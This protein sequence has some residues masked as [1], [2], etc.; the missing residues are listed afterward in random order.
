MN[1]AAQRLGRMAKGVKKT[2]S[3]EEI[4]RRTAQLERVRKRRW[5]SEIER[6]ED[7]IDFTKQMIKHDPYKEDLP[8]LKKHLAELRIHLAE[9]K[10]D[11]K[12]KH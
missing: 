2:D 12:R 8:G 1:R 5:L 10:R 6:I 9:A 3:P 7:D 11:L 4:A